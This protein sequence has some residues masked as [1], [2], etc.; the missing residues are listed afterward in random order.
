VAAH[1]GIGRL[2]LH[3]LQLDLRHPVTGEALSIQ[4]PLGSEW[5]CWAS[6]PIN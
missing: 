6:S 4:A 2:W 5:A 3:A 1:L